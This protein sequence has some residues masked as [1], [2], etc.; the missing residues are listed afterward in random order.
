LG[1][2]DFCVERFFCF[3][4]HRHLAVDNIANLTW[5]LFEAEKWADDCVFWPLK[6][7]VAGMQH[8]K[9]GKPHFAL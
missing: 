6:I 4:R 7:K 5:I 3:Q 8:L 2:Y 1:R 9:S